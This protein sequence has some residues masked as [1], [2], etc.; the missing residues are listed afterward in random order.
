MQTLIQR[1]KKEVFEQEKVNQPEANKNDKTHQQLHRKDQ[2]SIEKPSLRDGSS[3]SMR[4]GTVE[5]LKHS[6]MVGF[7]PRKKERRES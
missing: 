7:H 4:V 5:P 1:G 3:V 2:K 6:K